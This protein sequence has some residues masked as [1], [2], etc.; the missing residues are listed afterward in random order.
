MSHL[1]PCPGCNR[2]VRVVESQCPFCATALALAETPAP[3]L[4]RARLGRSATFAAG[5]SL[6][7]ASGTAACKDNTLPEPVFFDPQTAAPVY[8]LPAPPET[9]IA[10]T[11]PSP[12]AGASAS[13]ELAAG[14]APAV[15]P[16]APTPSSSVPPPKRYPA[17]I[18][19]G[20]PP[21]PK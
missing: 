4:P 18:Y 3:L 12:D 1:V 14:G 9:V 17:P 13:A 6:L 15:P 20:P 5:A 2:H 8:G 11:P 16:P 10:P 21:R 19:G 7:A